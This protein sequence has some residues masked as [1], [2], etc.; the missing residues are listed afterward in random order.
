[1]NIKITFVVFFVFLLAGCK[2]LESGGDDSPKGITADLS[3]LKGTLNE[4]EI[5]S[6]GFVDGREILI[7]SQISGTFGVIG[8]AHTFVFRPLD[9]Q[10]VSVSIKDKSG[11]L[12]HIKV[13]VINPALD[14]DEKLVSSLTLTAATFPVTAG[15]T[16]E[17]SV[18]T[19]N[20]GSYT[21]TLSDANRETMGL[22]PHDFYVSFVRTGEEQCNGRT[23]SYM[24][25]NLYYMFNFRNGSFVDNLNQYIQFYLTDEYTIGN[26]GAHSERANSSTYGGFNYENKSDHWFTVD[27]ITGSVTGEFRQESIFDYDDTSLETESCIKSTRFE[28][29]IIL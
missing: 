13:Y 22:G 26:S 12:E 3:H 2:L 15:Q 20:G 29:Q 14:D 17:V 1:M 4:P 7:N 21:V 8:N 11:S 24:P 28:G 27:H 19:D 5:T 6:L 16:Y 18:F 9:S 25:A 10:L 23:S